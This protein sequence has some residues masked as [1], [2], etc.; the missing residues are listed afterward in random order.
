MNLVLPGALVAEV[1]P[2]MEP[3]PAQDA[4]PDWFL[5][6]IVWREQRIPLVSVDALV[7]GADAVSGARVR[8][9]V[10]KAVASGPELNYYAIV[11]RG[12]PR[13]VSVSPGTVEGLGE[14]LSEGPAVAAE[15]LA[16]GEPAIIPDV[17]YIEAQINAVLNP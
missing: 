15:V 13:L 11:M 14:N 12:L 3:A 17:D 7:T 8:I 5:G 9:A 4:V 16:N 1:V 2:Y 6:S 10:L